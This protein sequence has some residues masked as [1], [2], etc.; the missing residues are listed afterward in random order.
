M[1]EVKSKQPTEPRMNEGEGSLRL[2]RVMLFAAVFASV[3]LISLVV[4]AIVG[5][6]TPV[7]VVVV[8]L[9]PA[10][11]AGVLAAR[12]HTQ[13]TLRVPGIAATVVFG[14]AIAVVAGFNV[15]YVSEHMATGRDPGV[16]LTIARWLSGHGDLLMEGRTGPFL[17]LNWVTANWSGYYETRLDG[18]LYAQF[19]HAFPSVLAALRW[20]FG[21][22]ALFYANTAIFVVGMSTVYLLVAQF[23]K[24][25]IAALTVS[26]AAFTVVAFYFARAT[27]SEPLMLVFVVF[28]LIAF[29][30][31][32][33]HRSPSA[34]AIAGIAI[35]ATAMIRIDGWVLIGGFVA[36]SAVLMSTLDPEHRWTPGRVGTVFLAPFIVGGFGIVDGLARSPSYVIDH[37]PFVTSMLA[38]VAATAAISVWLVIRS[39]GDSSSLLDGRRW[40][41]VHEQRL[42]LLAGWG[43][44]LGAG[45]FL[46]V[47][48]VFFVAR[49]A[50]AHPDVGPLLSD[51]GQ[52]GGA[53]RTLG[54]LTLRWF[55]WYWG[56]AGVALVVMGLL[57]LV[58]SRTPIRA[59][60]WNRAWFVILILGP[61]FAAYVLSPSIVPD[62]PW[63]MRR[64]YATALILIPLLQGIAFDWVERWTAQSAGPVNSFRRLVFAALVAIAVV[65]PV[66][67]S[68]PLLRVGPQAGLRGS[69]AELCSAM[70]ENPA[71]II[72]GDSLPNLGAAIR[73][74]CDVPTV[75]SAPDLEISEV[76]LLAHQVTDRGY[77]VV[78]VTTTEVI[79]TGWRIIG[80]DTTV[81]PLAEAILLRAPRGAI[82]SELSW[83]ASIPDVASA[84]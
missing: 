74:F 1:H 66:V 39:Y 13:P 68:L 63:A 59:R 2:D 73:S 7:A 83:I 26:I 43:I 64:F 25:W 17:G 34:I 6:F 14:I 9:V 22:G 62:Q 45:L 55:T 8:S 79:P 30:I 80:R 42:R 57:V 32:L 52:L 11:V 27:Y 51:E 81:F 37:L 49:G 48:P 82:S 47:R 5:A 54:E 69:I 67:V 19:L 77:G 50:T 44:V 33:R 23:V 72:H 16:Y 18:L 35:G 40:L 28:G 78:L 61:L 3:L 71:V 12:H 20:A 75:A 15:V 21:D 10:V 65:V 76:G 4:L 36:A 70:P 29:Y 31:G 53:G 60:R 46:F 84:P 24:D 41:A 58:W 38:F 56:W